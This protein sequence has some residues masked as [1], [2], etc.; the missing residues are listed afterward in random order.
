MPNIKIRCTKT[1]LPRRLGMCVLPRTSPTLWTFSIA[2]LYT[3]DEAL[4][5]GFVTWTADADKKS[6]AT[7]P[8]LKP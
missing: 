7:D 3:D 8:Q 5:S 6:S 4:F 2:G 1:R